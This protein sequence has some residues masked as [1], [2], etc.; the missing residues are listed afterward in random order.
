[1]KNDASTHSIAAVQAAFDAGEVSP[2]R[3]ADRILA[4]ITGADRGALVAVR[5]EPADGSRPDAQGG[6]LN[7]V[8]LVVK[9][10]IHVAGLPNTACTPALD[11]FMPDADAPVIARLRSA[12][13][14]VIAKA[15][16][17]ELSLGVTGIGHGFGTVR[18]AVDP[19]LMAGGSSSGVA[20]AVALGATAGIGT[21]TG[22]SV[23]IPAAL[24]GVVGFRPS[25]GRYP[26]SGITPLSDSRDTAGPI[27]HCVADAALLDAVLS[28]PGAIEP[29]TFEPAASGPAGTSTAPSAGHGAAREPDISTLTFGVPDDLGPLDPRTAEAF[30]F[31]LD[32]LR[33]AG[34]GIIAIPAGQRVGAEG[35]FGATILIPEINRLLT[36]YLLEFRP[37]ITLADLAAR[38]ENPLVRELMQGHVLPEPSPEALEAR[39]GALAETARLSTEEQDLFR[40]YKLDAVLFPTT[41]APAA[42]IN[43]AETVEIGGIAASSFDTYTRLTA[44]GTFIGAPGLTLPIPVGAGK[45]PVGLALDGVPGADEQLLAVGA[46]VERVFQA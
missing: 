26:G 41:P 25:T 6:V 18:N 16:M 7:G 42:P 36:R 46:A 15:G 35:T 32:A 29:G 33:T 40:E 38:I 39:L 31:A 11:G 1:M 10:N 44:Y 27:T 8:S 34:A 5:E 20:V 17:H 22:G 45:L 24:N 30:E 14:E 23:R 13:A 2:A 9:D 28:S 3:Y 21:D 37:G 4:R 12:G 43:P 19:T